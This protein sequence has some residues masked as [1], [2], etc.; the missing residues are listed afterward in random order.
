MD[1]GF[2]LVAWA[3]AFLLAVP[4]IA[5]LL[6]RRPPGW[7]ALL[8]PL[9]GAWATATFLAPSMHEWMWP[10]R[11]VVIAVPAMVVATAW[12]VAESR[13]RVGWLVALGA[14]GV[15]GWAWTAS[16]ALLGRLTL[17]VDFERTTSPTSTVWRPLLPDLG[18]PTMLTPLLAAAWVAVL[19]AL[20]VVGRRSVDAPSDRAGQAADHPAE[21]ASSCRQNG[22]ILAEHTGRQNTLVS[23]HTGL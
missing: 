21:P 6:R 16:E 18:Q 4:A 15:V 9:A 19:A 10:G 1:H 23:K 14:T 11:L 13:R 8:L 5:A 2:G 3:P 7:G 17:V 20:F 12:W 22:S